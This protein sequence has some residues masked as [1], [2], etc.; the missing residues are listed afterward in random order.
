MAVEAMR[1]RRIEVPPGG[2]WSWRV[3][4]DR[5]EAWRF[6][7][8]LQDGDPPPCRLDHTHVAPDGSLILP[9]SWVVLYRTIIADA[10]LPVAAAL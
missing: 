4:T 1:P 3:F 10:P 7:H 9:G 5:L 2:P 6:F 8:R